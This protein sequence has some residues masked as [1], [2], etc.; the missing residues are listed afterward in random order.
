MLIRVIGLD[1]M[2]PPSPFDRTARA[3]V[4]CPGIPD[5]GVSVA[6]VPR[7]DVGCGV[8][9]FEMVAYS[10]NQVSVDDHVEIAIESV[11]DRG[12][13]LRMSWS[14]TPECQSGKRCSLPGSGPRVGTP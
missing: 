12:V 7:T 14:V 13:T 9:P 5:G 11:A 4:G 1:G 10:A 2:W 6:S 3:A 8:A